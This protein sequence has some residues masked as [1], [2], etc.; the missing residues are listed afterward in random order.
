[1][2]VPTVSS[3]IRGEIGGIW[4]MSHNDLEGQEPVIIEPSTRYVAQGLTGYCD[5][6]VT[7]FYGLSNPQHLGQVT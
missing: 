6:I 7:L 1:M 3:P 2:P 5:Q 4:L